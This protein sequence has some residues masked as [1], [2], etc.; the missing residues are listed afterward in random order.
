MLAR[1]PSR[2]FYFFATASRCLQFTPAEVLVRRGKQRAASL[3]ARR[4]GAQVNQ[5]SVGPTERSIR[6]RPLGV[7][8]SGVRTNDPLAAAGVESRS[9]VEQLL[10]TSV[11]AALA[12]ARSNPHPW[13]RCQSLTAVAAEIESE[14]DAVAVLDEAL[15]AAT[16]QEEPNRVVSVASWPIGELV[17]RALRDVSADVAA[18]LTIIGREPNPVRRADALLSLLHAVIQEQQLRHDVLMPLL[19]A[20]SMSRGWKCRRILQVTALAL[21]PINGKM[22]EHVIS[23]IPESRESRRAKEMLKRRQW[24]WPR[25]ARTIKQQKARAEEELENGGPTSGCT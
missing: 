4:A 15:E 2:L 8:I 17:Q 23:R 7:T 20:C 18:L 19:S 3:V 9:K 12:E 5:G 1:R 6:F 11:S 25:Q 14:S 16:E 21:A 10:R 24:I 22:A 13:Y